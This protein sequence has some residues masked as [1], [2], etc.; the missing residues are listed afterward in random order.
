MYFPTG[1][2]SRFAILLGLTTWSGWSFANGYGIYDARTMSL[3]GTAV[4][5][6]SHRQGHFYNPSLTS[7][8]RGDEDRTTDG[9]HSLLLT[10]QATHGL[11][12]AY[13]IL[14]NDLERRLSDAVAQ[15]NNSPD[16][17]TALSAE[18]AA[19]ELNQALAQLSDRHLHLDATAGYAITEPGDW[20]GGTFYIGTR[21]IGSG[22]ANVEQS[23]LELLDDY[24]ATLQSIRAGEQGAVN[25]SL[26]D[27]DGQLIDPA[28][29]I[30]S[31]AS[32]TA[33]TFTEIGVSASKQYGIWGQT[34]AL[35]VTPKVMRIRVFD[36]NWR[37]DNGA[38]YVHSYRQTHLRFN[39]DLGAAMPIGEHWRFGLAVKD[40]LSR[41][42]TTES[43]QRVP[44]MTR[45][46]IGANYQNSALSAGF[47]VDLTAHQSFHGDHTR[48]D[49]SLAVAYEVLP[50]V[51]LRLGYRHDLQGDFDAELAAG[52]EIGWRRWSLEMAYLGHSDKDGV[53]LQ[54]SLSH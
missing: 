30:E 19:I 20:E 49:L 23:D 31:S 26:F 51:E 37:V 35:G 43:G 4:A 45:A 41:S 32:A 8:H 5:M 54:L 29:H 33:A 7:F 53:A 27:S 13:D 50:R 47:D 25:P 6:G 11:G 44:N 16:T 39:L 48:R 15:F 22:K 9:R 10:S 36:E 38:I 28:E 12:T 3:A 40:L 52:F 2:T 14:H 17:P 34:L 21:V 18:E 42:Y 46:R 24:I 1:N